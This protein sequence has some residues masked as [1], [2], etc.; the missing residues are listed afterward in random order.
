MIVNKKTCIIL[1]DGSNFY[2]KLK[3]LKFHNLLDFHFKQFS[4]YL[5]KQYDIVQSNYYVGKIR[6]DG[7]PKTQRL[8]NNQRK[9]LSYLKKNNYTYKL[10]YL[11][12]SNKTFHEKGVDI[13]IAVDIL[14]ATYEKQCD[15]IILVSS[16]TDLLPA[17]YKAREKGVFVEYIGFSHKP[18]V[19][20]KA[21]CNNTELLDKNIISTFIT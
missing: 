1:I 10:G 13:Q 19:A 16:D 15:K 14:V 20:M 18:S 5:A 21:R 9:L 7:T 3:D 4:K 17:I 11:M 12:K 6:T 8:F 2:F